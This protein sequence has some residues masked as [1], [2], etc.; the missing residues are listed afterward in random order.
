M[1]GYHKER[2]YKQISRIYD[3]ITRV[4]EIS[5]LK[6]IPAYAAADQ[7]AEERI[8]LLRNSRSTFLRNGQHALSR[9]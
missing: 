6:G 1:N 5:R 8:S 9:R 7:L 2:A 4:L 3:S